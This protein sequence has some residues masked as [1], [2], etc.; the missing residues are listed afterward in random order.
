MENEKKERRYYKKDEV[1]WL[2]AEKK[3]AIFK[4]LN[5]ET[6][7]ATVQ[8]QVEPAGGVDWYTSGGTVLAEFPIW[9]IDKLKYK[10]KQLKQTDEEKMADILSL[11]FEMFYPDVY[12]AQV[13]EGAIIPSKRDEDAGY[14][15]YAELENFKRETAE[16]VVYEIECPVL[17]T[18]LVPTGI[19]SAMPKTHYLNAKHERGSTA[20]QAMNVLAGVIDSGYRD[21]IFI[22]LTPLRKAVLI[23]SEVT[24]VEET[25]THILY[26]LG[27][28]IAQA[29]VDLVP[30]AKIHTIA[31][32]KLKEIASE[33]GT[34]KLG[35]S[36][37]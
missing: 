29:T 13:R 35:Q 17:A 25:E 18:T 10:A 7:M 3:E 12:F 32:D 9:E 31:Y 14:D 28:A 15:I 30:K 1:V 21:E 6:M 5:K 37:K 23:T 4:S 33:R 2:I 22:A 16:G 20:V 19:A 24:K 34:S 36:G 26:P 27:K 11:V 8:Y